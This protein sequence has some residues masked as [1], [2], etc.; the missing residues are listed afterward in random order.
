[1]A[2]SDLCMVYL[3]SLFFCIRMNVYEQPPSLGKRDQVSNNRSKYDKC[4]KSKNSNTLPTKILKQVFVNKRKRNVNWKGV[5]IIKTYPN[6]ELIMQC[7]TLERHFDSSYLRFQIN[8]GSYCQAL[9][10]LKRHYSG[11]IE[12]VSI[13]GLFCHHRSQ[14]RYL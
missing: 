7:T 3:C 14:K 13:K 1:M 8:V 10:P 11:Y 2:I 5:P 12:I 6:L 4:E 9:L